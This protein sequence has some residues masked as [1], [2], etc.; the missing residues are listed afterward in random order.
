MGEPKPAPL[1][2]RTTRA[3]VC[4]E[5]LF[6][7]DIQGRPGHAG[8]YSSESPGHQ[9]CP[10]S[11]RTWQQGCCLRWDP[12]PS[13]DPAGTLSPHRSLTLGSPRWVP[14]LTLV[15]DRAPLEADPRE[16]QECW[17]SRDRSCWGRRE[18]GSPKAACC[19]LLV[20]QRRCWMQKLGCALGAT[21]AMH[22]PAHSR[23]S[24]PD[25]RPPSDPSLTQPFMGPSSS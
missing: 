14:E 22:S 17:P 9:P 20:L 10:V 8:W 12:G 1:V 5:P 6:N 21:T 18:C 19:P 2:T 11:Q 4:A 15:R 16:A 23:K 24:H 3:Q 13:G 25:T 7:T